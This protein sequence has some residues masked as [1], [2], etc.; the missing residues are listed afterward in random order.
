MT[1]RSA[2]ILKESPPEIES[3]ADT[4]EFWGYASTFGNVD[5]QNDRIHKGAFAETIAAHF[6]SNQIKVLW[7][8]R[9][10]DPI[11]K[12]VVLHEDDHGLFFKAKLT[13]CTSGND[14]R[15]LM[16]DGVIDRTS[17]GFTAKGQ[18][19][20]DETQNGW[21]VSDIHKV[22]R[23]YEFSPVTFAAN[24][25]ATIE[26]VKSLLHGRYSDQ[27][28]ADEL[29]K[30]GPFGMAMKLYDS[31]G[32]FGLLPRKSPK[33]PDGPVDCKFFELAPADAELE[34]LDD[35]HP[36]AFLWVESGKPVL[37]IA[38]LTSSGTYQVVPTACMDARARLKDLDLTSAAKDLLRC[39]L[40]VYFT[41][42]SFKDPGLL[43]PTRGEQDEVDSLTE[44]AA[45]LHFATYAAKQ[46]RRMAE[47]VGANVE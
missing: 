35:S 2:L 16:R 19:S 17:I 10:D 44:E 23:L 40:D 14:A 7:Q 22:N 21:P 24:E 20:E 12:P 46:T 47:I 42:M 34:P 3:D 41:K 37:Q 4:R 11:G 45:I 38:N 18:E 43:I 28:F 25:L 29:R 15:N 1:E 39:H 9:Q 8:H 6:P 5:D 30:I 31:L 33:C 27:E 36:Q 13:D 32:G 26:G